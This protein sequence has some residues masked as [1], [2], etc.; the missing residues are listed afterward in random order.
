MNQNE[1]FCLKWNDF[2]ENI[3]TTFSGLRDVQ[4]FSDVTLA[5]EDN[6]FIETHRIVLSASSPF[7]LNLLQ[8]SK[9]QHPLIYLRGVKAQDLASILDFIYHGQAQVYQEDLQAFIGLA[10]ELRIKGLQEAEGTTGR[11][12]DKSRGRKGEETPVRHRSHEQQKERTSQPLA[13]KMEE[14]EAVWR[15]E[16]EE[17]AMEEY[18]GEEAMA[19]GSDYQGDPGLKV[20]LGDGGLEELDMQIASMMERGLEDNIWTCKVCGK[21]ATRGG[22]PDMRDHIEAN[23]VEGLAHPCTICGKTYK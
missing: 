23:H 20:F 21:K 10:K 1:K 4:D 3:G 22:K 16:Q 5:C 14:Q 18:R 6:Q 13:L 7:F 15:E 12:Q 19:G 11:V 17:G 9:H 2:H 8:R